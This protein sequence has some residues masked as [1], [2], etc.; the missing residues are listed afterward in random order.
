MILFKKQQQK[1]ALVAVLLLATLALLIALVL[2]VDAV[3]QSK[4]QPYEVS[5]SI[6]GVAGEPVF[7]AYDYGKGIRDENVRRLQLETQTQH[8]NFSV[9]GW[10]HVPAVYVFGSQQSPFRILSFELLKNGIPYT[11]QLPESGPTLEGENWFYRFPLTAFDYRN[12]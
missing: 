10:K 5:I 6:E 11:P 3:S 7:F 2:K 8:V 1:R 12:D 9:S 4:I